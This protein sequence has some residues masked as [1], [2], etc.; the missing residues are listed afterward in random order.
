MSTGREKREPCWDTLYPRPQSTTHPTDMKETSGSVPSLATMADFLVC[1]MKDTFHVPMTQQGPARPKQGQAAQVYSLEPHFC[2]L[3]RVLLVWLGTSW[4][5]RVRG[6]LQRN[7]VEIRT[8]SNWKIDTQDGCVSFSPYDSLGLI[9]KACRSS[10]SPLP[11]S[12]ILSHSSL[13]P[14]LFLPVYFSYFFSI[15]SSSTQF[16][17][18]DLIIFYHLLTSPRL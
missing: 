5:R 12:L 17:L 4:K 11:L 3:F 6:G 16:L 13:S 15:F 10:L 14:C 2:G 18:S 8:P 1:L 9:S 7:C